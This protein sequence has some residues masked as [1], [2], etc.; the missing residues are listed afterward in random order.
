MLRGCSYSRTPSPLGPTGL[1]ALQPLAAILLGAPVAGR[2]HQIRL[3]G[4]AQCHD[5]GEQIGPGQWPLQGMEDIH[6]PQAELP[7]PRQC[8]GL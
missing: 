1:P 6:K 8:N 2:S 5:S 7:T 4:I 3:G